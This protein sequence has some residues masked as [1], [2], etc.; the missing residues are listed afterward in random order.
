MK[1][2]LA[3]GLTA[4][5]LNGWLAAIGITVLLPSA[6]LSWTDQP[7]PLARF[8]Y[9]GD[10]PLSALV[11][12]ALPDIDRLGTLSIHEIPRQV[13]LA[14]YRKRAM[15]ARG[16]GDA[17]GM[18]DFSLTSSM[19]DLVNDPRWKAGEEKLPHS[20]FDPAAPG[21]TGSVYDR[22]AKCLKELNHVAPNAVEAIAASLG[23]RGIRVDA[24][25]LG[26]DHRRL[27]S[28]VLAKGKVQVDPV[29]ELLC[30]FGLA[31]FPIRGDGRRERARGWGDR[32]SK[33][34]AFYWPAW[35]QQL[36]AWGIDALLDR[37][38]QRP[39]DTKEL[40]RYGVFASFLSVPYQPMADNDP[41]RAYASERVRWT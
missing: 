37:F 8:S 18:G 2:E 32:S 26:F 13:T 1:E 29:A 35:N 20:P 31:L 16:D 9:Q 4:D 28:G 6:R 15:S 22:L 7:V 30:Y 24:N 21:T 36:D 19:T 5:W 33:R 34:G 10:R 12:T 11:A 27:V 41:T 39:R 38:H 25:G 17:W 14:E 3:P 40:S 23:S